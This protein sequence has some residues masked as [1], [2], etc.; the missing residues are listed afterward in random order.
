MDIDLTGKSALVTGSTGGI[1]YAVAKELAKL[2]AYVAV[3]GRTA[4][5]VDAAIAQLREEVAGG[6]FIA[7]VGSV[8]SAEGVAE[9]VAGLPKVDILINNAGIFEPKPFFEIE[10]G[11]WQRFFDVNVMSGVRLSRAYAPG[12][13]ERG[14]GRVVFIASESAINIPSEMVHYGMT[15][16]AQLAVSRG[17][18]ETVGGSGVTVNSV[19]PGPTLTE[20]VADFLKSMGGAGADLEETGKSF[21]AENRPTSLIKRLARPE[22]VAS[23]VAYLCTPAASATTGAAL[24]VDGGVLRG[25]A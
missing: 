24:R 3:N 13:V 9:L 22:E 11:D 15:K 12:M 5:R 19:L 21:I 25:I 10:D 16:T 23:M 17:L 7:G 20:G 14:W 4:E 8:S 18:A 2:G 1:G 6:Q